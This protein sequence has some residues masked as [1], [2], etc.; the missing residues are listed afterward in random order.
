MCLLSNLTVYLLNEQIN[1]AN[2]YIVEINGIEYT[3]S[4]LF[5]ALE[6]EIS[7]YAFTVRVKAIPSVDNTNYMESEYSN[8][9]QKLPSVTDIIVGEQD[10]TWAPVENAENYEVNVNG[11]SYPTDEPYFSFASWAYGDLNIE[12]IAKGLNDKISTIDSN[13]TI[14]QLN[15]LTNNVFCESLITRLFGIKSQMQVNIF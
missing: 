2:R 3:T 5:Y 8:L 15:K 13:P 6:E 12:I 4:N 7:D 14:I 10:I 9:I 1:Q 11:Y